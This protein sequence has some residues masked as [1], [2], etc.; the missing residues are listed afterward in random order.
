MS[1]F[2]LTQ[3]WA[4]LFLLCCTITGATTSS[5]PFLGAPVGQNR[6]VVAVEVSMSFMTPCWMAE[7]HR[8]KQSA[9]AQLGGHINAHVKRWQGIAISIAV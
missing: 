2:K 1:G 5:C 6:C 7:H 8:P 4:S 9:V 3:G